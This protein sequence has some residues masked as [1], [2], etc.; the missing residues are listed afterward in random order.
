MRLQP[1]RSIG[2]TISPE[3]LRLRDRR[4]DQDLH[5]QL[6]HRVRLILFRDGGLHSDSFPVVVL[7]R[8]KALSSP[9]APT[10]SSMADARYGLLM[11]T[12]LTGS[13]SCT[14]PCPALAARTLPLVLRLHRLWTPGPGQTW[15]KSFGRIPAT[16]STQVSCGRLPW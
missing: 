5:F 9:T 2:F 15:V 12:T 13:T 4:E 14:T 3:I 11:S 1:P 10:S 16:P 6:A 7:G 8:V